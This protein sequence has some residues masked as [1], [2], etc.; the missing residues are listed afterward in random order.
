MLLKLTAEQ[1]NC[2]KITLASERFQARMG[3]TDPVVREYQTLEEMMNEF[4]ENGIDQ[5]DFDDA[6]HAVYKHLLE[7]GYSLGAALS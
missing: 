1:R 5:A 4:E 6:A 7:K 2:V 3:E